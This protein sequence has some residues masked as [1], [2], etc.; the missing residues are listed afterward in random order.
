MESPIVG[1]FIVTFSKTGMEEVIHLAIEDLD[2]ARG[3]SVLVINIVCL[4]LPPP[5][6]A[7]CSSSGFVPSL[8]DDQQSTMTCLRDDTHHDI[9]GHD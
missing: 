8:V 3:C 4:S 5:T 2:L 7:L 9:Q 1:T 6:T